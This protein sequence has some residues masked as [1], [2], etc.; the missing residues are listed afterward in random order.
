MYIHIIM[1]LP[2]L[3]CMWQPE[4]RESSYSYQHQLLLGRGCDFAIQWLASIDLLCSVALNEMFRLLQT[5][6]VNWLTETQAARRP[7][8]EQVK[9]SKL[10]KDL[11]R[12][13]TESSE[14]NLIPKL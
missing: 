8:A 6:L 5:E 14:R 3:V 2:H 10:F 9:E 12:A 1:Q 13:A 4:V 7:T 11:L